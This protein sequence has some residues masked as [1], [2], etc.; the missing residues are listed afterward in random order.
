MLDH[1]SLSRTLAT[2]LLAGA[3]ALGL[4]AAACTKPEGTS[5]ASTA[6]T[7]AT[8]APSGT[9]SAASAAP[10]ASPVAADTT[11]GT[12][13]TGGADATAPSSTSTTV[14]AAT[15]SASGGVAPAQ[16][17]SAGATAAACGTKPLPDCPLQA[18]MK[19]NTNPA[20]ASQDFPGLATA[21]DKT[22]TFAPAG[23]TNWASI[24]KD[25][26]KAARA[27]DMT[28]TKASCRTCHDQYKEKYKKELRGRKI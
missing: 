27:S 2:P 24:A 5:S 23:Y 13:P 10:D 20:I 3:L 6:A 9:T 12:Q 18:W 16:S 11:T 19:A 1:G 21:L 14:T 4:L 17:A 28:A 15:A 7:S 8:A 25:G 22:A 26:A